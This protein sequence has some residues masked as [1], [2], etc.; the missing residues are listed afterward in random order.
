MQAAPL[1]TPEDWRA[2]SNM[3]VSLSEYLITVSISIIAGQVAL[4]AALLG[5]VVRPTAYH[6]ASLLASILLVVSIVY[7]GWATAD[8]YKAGFDGIWRNNAA[9]A[10]KFNVQAEF[11]LLGFVVVL[12]SVGLALV[13]KK[14]TGGQEHKNASAGGKEVK[15]YLTIASVLF[16]LIALMHALRLLFGWSVDVGPWAI[17]KWLSWIALIVTLFLGIWGFRLRKRSP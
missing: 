9:A 11:L 12:V 3:A 6:V 16:L 4:A 15:S 5:K 17:P 1:G 8:V 14:P 10:Q 2:A 7:G 13:P